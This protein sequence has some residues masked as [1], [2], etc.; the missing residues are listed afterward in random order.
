MK[1]PWET[2]NMKSFMLFIKDVVGT[3]WNIEWS[4]TDV[5]VLDQI[6]FLLFSLEFMEEKEAHWHSF[7]LY[8]LYDQ[9]LL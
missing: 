7:S 2:H 6:C 4:T 9:N 1:S 5:G 8:S 3:D